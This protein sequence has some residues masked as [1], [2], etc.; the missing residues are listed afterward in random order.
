MCTTKQTGLTLAALLL[1]G[2]CSHSKSDGKDASVSEAGVSIDSRLSDSTVNQLFDGGAKQ[3]DGKLDVNRSVDA[4]IIDGSRALDGVSIVDVGSNRDVIGA[5]DMALAKDGLDV[6]AEVGGIDSETTPNGTCERP[7]MI[8][9]GTAAI[10]LATTTLDR[11]HSVDPSCAEGGNDVVFKFQTNSDEM[12]YAHTFGA[13]W[14]T[15]LVLGESCP[16]ARKPSLGAGQISCNDDACGTQQSQ[17]FAHLGIGTHYLIVSGAN[18]ESGDVMVHFEHMPSAS[19]AE[20]LP[21][22]A[23]AGTISGTTTGNTVTSQCEAG[24][25]EQSYWWAS[26]PDY[27]GGAFSATTCSLTTWDTV[28]IL[29]VPRGPIFQCGDDDPNCGRQ[30]TLTSTIPVGAGLHMLTIDGATNKALGDYTFSYVRP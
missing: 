28:F 17:V 18:G 27:A 4:N 2:A 5:R 26:C 7:F 11:P 23:G 8:S 19:G 10:D 25:P 29:Q 22:P 14:N 9:L 30:S 3:G 21:L 6:P 15:I 13:S 16:G 12:V 20:I 1:L 24:G